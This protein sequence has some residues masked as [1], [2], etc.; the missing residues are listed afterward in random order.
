MSETPDNSRPDLSVLVASYN[1]RELLAACL[2][3]LARATETLRTEI[4]VVDNSSSDGSC[5]MVA[6]DFPEVRLLRNTRNEG[7]AKANNRALTESRGRFVLL[8]NPDTL[9]PQDTIEPMVRFLEAHPRVGMAGCRVDRPDGRLDEACKREFPT[10]LTA[11]ARFLS[12]DRLFPRSTALAAYSKLGSDPSGRY[13]VDAVVGAFMLV[14]RETVDDVGGL[15]EDFFMFGED[16]D[17]CY[18]V[19]RK[20]WKVYY[21]GDYHVVHHKGAATRQDPH[22]MNWHFHRSMFLFHRK[23][24]VDHYPFFVNWLV[25]AGI[26]MRYALKSAWTVLQPA[27]AAARLRATEA[28]RLK[29]RYGLEIEG[30]SEAGT[31]PR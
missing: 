20:D 22:R 18:R 15:D 1:T 8:L 3:T 2:A 27:P 7:F 12:L 23:H 21:V 30:G 24:L 11:I 16:L 14:R 6:R 25:Y 29:T 26:T 10:P 28:A 17:W 9:I 4:I 13:E 5:E 19:K 31:G